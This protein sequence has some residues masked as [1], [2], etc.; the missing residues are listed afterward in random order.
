M[1]SAAL[2]VQLTFFTVAD[3]PKVAAGNKKNPRAAGLGV[4]RGRKSTRRRLSRKL[5]ASVGMVVG[6]IFQFLK[7][8]FQLVVG[9]LR[10]TYRKVR[11][12]W[13]LL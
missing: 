1:R 2:F 7:R 12:D 9:L 13:G 6:A 4:S 10:L 3:E 11:E 5:K 8:I